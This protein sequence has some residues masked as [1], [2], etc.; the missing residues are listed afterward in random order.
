MADRFSRLFQGRA[1]VISAAAAANFGI[2]I[3]MAGLGLLLVA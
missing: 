2:R 1:K 3:E